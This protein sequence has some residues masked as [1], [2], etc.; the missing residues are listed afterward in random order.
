MFNSMPIAVS[1]MQAATMRL[2]ASAS[3]IAN[4][5]S[6]GALPGT[7]QSGPGAAGQAYVPVRVVQSPLVLDGGIGGGTVA[8]IRAVRQA[9][10]ESHEP[11]S[12]YANSDGMVAMP[13]VDPAQEMLEQAGAALSFK[14]N[15]KVFEASSDM[16]RTLLD[17]TDHSRVYERGR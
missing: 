6:A 16:I 11:A 9:Y 4:M 5:N 15:A 2:E 17:M 10:V 3:N 8:S 13:N 14:L 1:G 7:V 12:A